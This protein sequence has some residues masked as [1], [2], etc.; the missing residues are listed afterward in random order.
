MIR[1]CV[2]F[3]ASY[4]SF[5]YAK[6]QLYSYPALPNKPYQPQRESYERSQ[7]NCKTIY[8]IEREEKYEK[9]CETKYV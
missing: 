4:C 8:D 2:L 6:P 7:K 5:A 1:F 9:K 3:L